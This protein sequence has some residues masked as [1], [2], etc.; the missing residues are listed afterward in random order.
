[1]TTPTM[2]YFLPN[3]W[4]PPLKVLGRTPWL[5]ILPATR[6]GGGH[7]MRFSDDLGEI[8]SEHPWFHQVILSMSS[9]H[10]M[11]LQVLAY[12]KLLANGP[13]VV[14][15]TS[16]QCEAL[17]HVDLNLKFREYEQPFPVFIVEIPAAYRVKLTDEYHF[18]CPRFVIPYYD[19]EL[20]FLAVLADGGKTNECV[21][22]VFS[23]SLTETEME[24]GLASR[25]GQDGNDYSQ[26]I[27]L[28]R[29]AINLSLLLTRYGFQNDGPLDSKAVAKQKK[30]LG[31]KSVRKAK[32]AR[33]LLDA[34]MTCI[35]LSQDVQFVGKAGVSDGSTG[36]GSKKTPHW[37]RGHFRH[38]RVGPGRCESRLTF[39]PPILI[40]SESFVGEL[41]DTEYCIRTGGAELPDQLGE[42][43]LQSQADSIGTAQ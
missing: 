31:G 34:S 8:L 42:R 6:A 43:H 41:A 9:A 13:K 16:E 30:L 5:R 12:S 11:L 22:T 40:N 24:V 38:Q 7:Q 14:R 28:E 17:S 29:I 36:T 33:R 3:E 15:P 20:P 19:R 18:P 26:A 4:I 1:M 32:R 39:I 27:V 25:N 21:F 2:T 37:R 10:G 23:P 35:S